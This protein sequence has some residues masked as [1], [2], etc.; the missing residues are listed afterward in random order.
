MMVT[1]FISSST[2]QPPNG[3]VWCLNVIY[4]VINKEQASVIQRLDSAIQRT[5]L[6]PVDNA[7]SFA[8]TYLLYS[9]LSIE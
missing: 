8:N 2:I 6:Y 5:N 4:S 9:D 7:I 3:I 1:I